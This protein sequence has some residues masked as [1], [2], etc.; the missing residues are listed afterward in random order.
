ML[1]H[2]PSLQRYPSLIATLSSLI[3]TLSL[4]ATLFQYLFPHRRVPSTRR[5]R[6]LKEGQMKEFGWTQSRQYL[7]ER[8]FEDEQHLADWPTNSA[9]TP[10]GCSQADTPENIPTD[11]EGRIWVWGLIALEHPIR[12]LILVP[13]GANCFRRVG[14]FFRLWRSGL[15]GF[16]T[17]VITVV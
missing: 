16:E 5:F 15:L 17:R 11:K 4:T 2:N 9:G 3:A 7:K 13:A 12:E 1:H 6:I 8:R 14:A 10:V